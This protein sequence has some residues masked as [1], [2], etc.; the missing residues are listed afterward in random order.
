[1]VYVIR[2][3]SLKY[4]RGNYCIVRCANNLALRF[5]LDFTEAK[6][7]STLVRPRKQLTFDNFQ[8]SQFLQEDFICGKEFLRINNLFL[9]NSKFPLIFQWV[10]PNP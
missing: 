9:S 5:L 3:L 2:K 7:I 8:K 1:M 4:T 10:K 6:I